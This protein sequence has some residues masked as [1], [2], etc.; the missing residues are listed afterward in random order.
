VHDRRAPRGAVRRC[1]ILGPLGRCIVK[2]YPTINDIR[3]SSQNSSHFG[4]SENVLLAPTWD[5]RVSRKDDRIIKA[6]LFD[7]IFTSDRKP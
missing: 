3:I 4:I 2:G 1:T 7:F 6:A 5:S